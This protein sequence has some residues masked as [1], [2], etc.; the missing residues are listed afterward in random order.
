MRQ[1]WPLRSNSTLY[2]ENQKVSHNIFLSWSE[3]LAFCFIWGCINWMTITFFS[4]TVTRTTLHLAQQPHPTR[5]SED[6]SLSILLSGE[7]VRAGKSGRQ[8]IK[9]KKTPKLGNKPREMEREKEN[10]KKKS[11]LCLQVE[12]YT[13]L[14]SESFSVSLL[15]ILSE[16]RTADW[17]HRAAVKRRSSSRPNWGSALGRT[18]LG[19]W[20]LP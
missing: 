20:T 17:W 15:L 5:A 2:E 14:P 6:S 11:I 1:S 3:L 12:K 7:G 9:G 19:E 10:A 8:K 18:G 4:S 13:L 16:Q